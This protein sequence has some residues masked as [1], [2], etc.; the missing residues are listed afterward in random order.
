MSVSKPDCV[1]CSI[2]DRSSPARIVF[3]TDLVFPPVF[4]SVVPPSFSCRYPTRL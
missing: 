3:E 2:V 1:F 4:V